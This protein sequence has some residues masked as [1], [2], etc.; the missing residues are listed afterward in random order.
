V[1]LLKL[2]PN[3]VVVESNRA[4]ELPRSSRCDGRRDGLA[5]LCPK[6][7]RRS[8]YPFCQGDGPCGGPIA[9]THRGEPLPVVVPIDGVAVAKRLLRSLL[10]W[11]GFRD[12][13][14]DPFGR[15][16]GCECHWEDTPAIIVQDRECIKEPNRSS[17]ER[18]DPSRRSRRGC[19]RKV[20]QFSPGGDNPAPCTWQPWIGNIDA[21][22]QQLTIPHRPLQNSGVRTGHQ[23][24]SVEDRRARGASPPRPGPRQSATGKR[25]QR[26]RRLRHRRVSI[27]HC[28]AI[29]NDIA[30]SVGTR[31]DAVEHGY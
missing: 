14:R 22:L 8:I 18:A 23:A 31:F 1:W 16:T 11:K 4:L 29:S 15:G 7:T 21:E 9:D 25:L 10:P 2:G 17:A 26:R 20:F 5:R 28:H 12:L 24:T 6:P 13:S 3:A 30:G 27:D 19:C